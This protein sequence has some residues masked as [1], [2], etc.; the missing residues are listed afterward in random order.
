MSPWSRKP[1]P[2]ILSAALAL[3]ILSQAALLPAAADKPLREQFGQSDVPVD[4]EYN[5]SAKYAYYM[6]VLEEYDEY[7]YAPAGTEPAA[8]GIAQ[9]Q[10]ENQPEAASYDGREA[11]LWDDGAGYFEWTVTAPKSGLYRLEL[12]YY[13]PEG[14]E[15]EAVRTLTLDGSTPFYE[16]NNLTFAP[17]WKESGKPVA[18]SLGDE[19]WPEQETVPRWITADIQDPN[20]LY[21]EPFAFYLEAGEHTFRLEYVHGTMAVGEL[22]LLSSDP[23]PTY[24]D[25]SA[26]YDAAG[27]T[28]APAGTLTLQAEDIVAEKND[29]SVRREYDGDPLTV[30]QSLYNRRLN[31]LG[32]YRWRLGGQSV[33][34]SFTVEQDGLYKIGMRCLQSWNDGLPS[35]RKIRVDGEVPFEELLAYR[36]AYSSKWQTET[37]RG[38]DGEPFLFY[39][40]AGSHT[41]TMEVTA[42]P[43]TDVIYSLNDDTLALSTMI[44][45][46][47]EITGNEPDPNYD[48][49]LFKTIPT[50]KDDLQALADSMQYKYDRICSM[51]EKTP[52][53]AN[54]FLTIQAQMEAMIEDDYVIPRRIDDLE[55][56]MTSLGNWYQE[57]Q[58]QPLM[59]DTLMVGSPSDTWVH[60]NSS[61]LSRAWAT[62]VNFFLSFTKDYDNVGSVLAEDTEV[63]EILNVWVAY[64][65]EWAEQI[66]E[67]ADI[68]FTPETGI[69]VNV[70]V[71]PSGQLNAGSVN[72][73]MLSITSGQAP[74]V[75]IGTSSSSP[76]EFAIRD[77]TVNLEQFDDFPEVKSRFLE[78][79]FVPFEYNGGTYA[80]PDT[81]NFNVMYYRTDILT[82]LN[83]A[84]PE[85]RQ[86]LYDDVL[87]VLYQNNMEFF[88][89]VDF[90]QFIFQHGAEYYTED[91]LY[92]A[93][94]TPEAF[95]AFKEC[96]ELYTNYGVPVSADFFNRFRSGEMPIGISN[97]RL[98]MLFTAAAPE[99]AGRWAIAPIPGTMREDGTIDRSAGG[100]AAE[101]TIILSQSTKQDAAWEFLKW[102][103]STEAQTEFAHNIE[104]LV[105]LE[106]RWNSANI[107]AFRSLNWGQGHLEV[108][109]EYWQWAKEPPVVLGS[110]YT[111]RHL[112]NAWNRVII[113]GQSVR[114]ALEEAVD[115]INRELRMKQEE[116]GVTAE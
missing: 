24:A 28:E 23:L 64:G 107:E 104:S 7:G 77:A 8:Y 6:D 115:D 34:L 100:L 97:F 15:E 43:Y 74:D 93:L 10:A 20:G 70:N 53:M 61:L 25:I 37:L 29:S 49:K 109:E 1:L 68:Q 85:T 39:L 94:D 14:V 42:A 26:G 87:P 116:Y 73:L 111:A 47:Q 13:M 103:T 4:Y 79:I 113:N 67:L 45:D 31:V 62:L 18:N 12:D 59:L 78:S 92:S 9:I 102:W 88:F 19:V 22:R 76:T 83:L 27:Y 3:L 16:A 75:A 11:L 106:G 84:L 51:A 57:L 81:M 96:A 32:G 114:D 60:K 21:A 82:D 38:Q 5:Q 65:T 90:S 98:Y 52:A 99:L 33:T 56:A 41:L 55:N 50:L 2:R 40:K 72:P 80:L 105:G 58:S 112:N 35:Y 95:Q 91:G 30:P 86:D 69:L 66:K 46:I 108:I 110:A 63:K 36:F 54:N 48:Y 71:L 17:L 89:P 101:C 44:R